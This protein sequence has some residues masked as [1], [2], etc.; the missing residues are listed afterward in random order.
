MSIVRHIRW[1]GSDRRLRMGQPHSHWK[2]STFVAGLT[3][4]GMIAPF[5]LA[6]PINR[7]AFEVQIDGALVPELRPGDFVIMDNLS[8]HEERRVRERIEAVG[9]ELRVPA[10][11]TR[12][13]PD[14]DS[15]LEAQRT[16]AQ[17]R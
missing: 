15:P 1:F 16:L 2:T 10:L 12:S 11:L 13:Q 8:S 3:P 7:L 9:A 5:V 14:R 4:G 6:G 17:G